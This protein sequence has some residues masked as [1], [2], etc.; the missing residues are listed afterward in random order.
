MKSILLVFFIFLNSF[1]Y[2]LIMNL[3][4]PFKNLSKN[5]KDL[6]EI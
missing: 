4:F 5:F 3:L 1:L 6:E 2:L